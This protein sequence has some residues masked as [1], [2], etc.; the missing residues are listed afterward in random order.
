VF[1][2]G[3]LKYDQIIKIDGDG[4]IKIWKYSPKTIQVNNL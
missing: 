3:L 1:A 4:E 2:Y